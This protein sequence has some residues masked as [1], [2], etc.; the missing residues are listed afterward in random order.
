MDLKK[1]VDS[2][3]KKYNKSELMKKG[4]EQEKDKLTSSI[5]AYEKD[6]KFLRSTISEKN[7][8][9]GTMN[10]DRIRLKKEKTALTTEK[11][12]LSKRLD[13]SEQIK[14]TQRIDLVAYEKTLFQLKQV[15][16]TLGQ[17]KEK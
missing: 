15:V 14:I 2:W 9:I 7:K 11:I 16:H 5:I 12:D 3:S 10:R 17:S 13:V 4:I 6:V 1:L 8:I